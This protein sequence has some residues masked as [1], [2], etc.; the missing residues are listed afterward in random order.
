MAK[1]NAK[2]GGRSKRVKTPFDAYFAMLE[3]QIRE[4]SEERERNLTAVI[5][6]LIM[7]LIGMD[8]EHRKC[9]VAVLR[10]QTPQKGLDKMIDRLIVMLATASTKETFVGTVGILVEFGPGI[11]ARAMTCLAKSA[12]RQQRLGMLT[13]IGH[14]VEK[15]ER[16]ELAKLL[17]KLKSAA[18]QYGD[19]SVEG[20]AH[21]IVVATITA[22]LKARP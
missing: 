12:I 8:L 22:K 16:N 1:E 15:L 19:G 6:C 3:N 18:F 7:Q 21:A 10:G 2:D 13:V 11:V 17:R 20:Q 5:D 14:S 4:A 9:Q